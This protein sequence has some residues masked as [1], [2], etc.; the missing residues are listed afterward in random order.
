MLQKSSGLIL[1]YF[2]NIKSFSEKKKKKKK[3]N[4]KMLVSSNRLNTLLQT[5]SRETRQWFFIYCLS[6]FLNVGTTFAF[7]YL[8]GNLPERKQFSKIISSG[9][10][11][12]MLQ[13]FIIQMLI[14]LWPWV[15]LG[16]TFLIVLY[17][18]FF[19]KTVVS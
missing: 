3:K 12:D 19:E 4:E 16:S 2:G 17:I 18:S 7:F 6:P 15:L 13:S 9:L 11:M 14:M 5:V 8:E 1:D 10:H